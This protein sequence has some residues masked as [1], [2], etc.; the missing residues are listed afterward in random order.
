MGSGKTTVGRDLAAR[1]GRRHRDTDAAVI[2]GAGCSIEE[3]FQRW[4]EPDFRRRESVA[5]ADI[6]DGPASV[7]ST[8]GGIVVSDANRA[9]LAGIS[10]SGISSL[11]VWLD[12]G[13]D[14]LVKRVRHGRGRPLLDGDL[15][16]NL[17]TKVTERAALYEEV[18]DI[19][20][21]TT[22]FSRPAAV[23]RILAAIDKVGG[24]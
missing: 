12:A 8:G 18:A 9:M 24:L 3:I 23:G 13:V 17:V 7:I 11:I 4:G 19:R 20:I 1:L 15:R 10:P 16:G 14:V 6:L 5:L 2:D 22:E 21:D